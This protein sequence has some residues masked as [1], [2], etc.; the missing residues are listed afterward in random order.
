MG[1]MIESLSADELDESPASVDEDRDDYEI[2]LVYEPNRRA[3]PD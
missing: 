3:F 2:G 1:N